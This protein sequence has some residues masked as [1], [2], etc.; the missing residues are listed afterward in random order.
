[1]LQTFF[2]SSST[3]TTLAHA[4]RTSA[5]PPGPTWTDKVTAWATL[6]TALGVIAAGIAA[7]YAAKQVAESKRARHADIAVDMSR[8]WDETGLVS[9]RQGLREMTPEAVKN[10]YVDA[11][12]KKDPGYFDMQL[13]PN[14][15]EDLAVLEKMRIVDLEW[16]DETLGGATMN[17]WRQW[18][19]AVEADRVSRQGPK[20][21]ENFEKLAEK[22]RARRGLPPG[23]AG[24]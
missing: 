19:L 12:A 1:M 10:L 7:A 14:F 18:R 13:L 5:A 3:V 21:F 15:F 4:V 11:Y 24:S 23:S 22:I 2:S 8:R 6:G 20:L 9:C 16:I 17:Y